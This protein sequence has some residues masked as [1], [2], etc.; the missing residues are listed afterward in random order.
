MHASC[1]LFHCPVTPLPDPLSRALLPRRGPGARPRGEVQ[2]R[3]PLS[4][5]FCLRGRGNPLSRTEW[6]SGPRDG[7]PYPRHLPGRGLARYRLGHVLHDDLRAFAESKFPGQL[8]RREHSRPL[9]LPVE[10]DDSV[11][12]LSRL[13]RRHVHPPT[14]P[15]GEASAGHEDRRQLLILGE[16]PL[17]VRPTHPAL[18]RCHD[19]PGRRKNVLMHE[20]PGR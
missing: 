16:S 3:G 14:V 17:L 8:M 4:R 1:T 18:Q 6:E 7:S 5:L 19:E 20:A 15:A 9:L 13:P 12:R 10:V 11:H 2:G